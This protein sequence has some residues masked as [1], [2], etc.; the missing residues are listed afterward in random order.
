[1]SETAYLAHPDFVEHLADELGDVAE[2][3]DR[4]LLAP[5]PARPAVWA[6]NIWHEP[7]RIQLASIGQGAKALRALQR[8][9]TWYPYAQHGRAKLLREKLPYVSG[10]PLAFRQPRP[11]APLGSWTLLDR[12][13]LLCAPRCSSAFPN[14]EVRFVE[15]KRIP[16]T[17]AYLKLWEALTLL[18]VHPGPSDICLDLGSCPGGWTWVLQQLGAHVISVDKAPL[19]P[20]IAAL[21]GIEFRQES[22]FGLDPRAFERVDWLFSDVACYPER[23]LRLVNRWL[24]SG[25]CKRFVCTIKLQGEADPQV[26]QAFGAIPGATVRHLWHNKHELTFLL[27]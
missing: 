2:R 22:A 3:H 21:P 23:L 8:G 18:D 25:V 4:L 14:G 6:Q 1:M 10:K 13:T 24:E 27:V 20:R 16:P 11:G 17:R 15:D 12:D 9:W 26:L 5:G 7:Q 19:D